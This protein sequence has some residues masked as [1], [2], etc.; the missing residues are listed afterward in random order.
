MVQQRCEANFRAAVFV[1]GDVTARAGVW[2][3][4]VVGSSGVC[5]GPVCG[6]PAGAA[7]AGCGVGAR[8]PAVKK[9][10]GLFSWSANVVGRKR[11]GVT[12]Q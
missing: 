3:A 9:W 10:L 6:V 8:G 4:R 5:A 12:S 1:A 2:G 7:P 11:C